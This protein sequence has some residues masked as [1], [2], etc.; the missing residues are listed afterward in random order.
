MDDLLQ[1]FLTEAAE[2]LAILDVELVKF[3]QDPN[4]TAI[5]QNIFRLVHTVKG[6]C[7]FLGLSRLEAV[8]HA[9]ENVLGKFRD[10][11]LTV[12]PLAV[13]LILRCL[14]GIRAILGVLEQTGQEPAG[15]DA[16]LI[17]ELNALASGEAPAA[18]ASAPAEV[19]HNDDSGP[20]LNEQ[21]FPV[22]AELLAEVAQALAAQGIPSSGLIDADA[23][24]QA[25]EARRAT[26]SAAEEAMLA[27]MSAEENRPQPAAPAPVAAAPVAAAPVAAAPAAGESKDSAVAGASIRV[28]VDILENLMTLVS[29][30]VLTRNQLLQMVRVREDSEFKTP[31][32]R[33]SHITTE[34]Q[35]GVMKSRMQPIGNAWSKLPRIVRDLSMELD[36][37]VELVMQGADT[38]LDR[39]LLELIKDPLTHMV[40]NSVDHGLEATNKDRIAAGK[41]EV[42]KITLKAY[43]EGGHIIISIADDGRGLNAEK[44]RAKALANGLVTEAELTS[45]SDHQLYQFIFRAGFSTAEKVTNVSGRGV[46]MDVV[47]SNIEKIGGTI[48][49]RSAPNKGTTFTIK[50]PLTLAIVSAL[51]VECAKQRFAIPQINVLELVRASRNSEARI[52]E[53]NH[54]PVLRLRDRLLPLVSLNRLLKIEDDAAAAEDS[55]SIVIAQVGNTKFGMIV[56]R[57]FDTEEIVVKPVSSLMRNMPVYSGNT[58]LGDGNVIMILDPHGIADSLGNAQLEETQTAE[59]SKLQQSDSTASFLL[60]RAVGQEVKAIPLGLVTRIERIPAANVEHTQGRYVVQYRDHLMPLV[61]FHETQEWQKGETYSVLVFTEKDRSV[62]LV[63]DAIVDIVED[64]MDIALTANQPGLLGSAVI[65]GSATD[66]IDAGHFLTLGFHDWF[67]GVGHADAAPSDRREVLLV[68][69]SLFFRNLMTPYLSAAG[70]KVT[71]CPSAEEALALRETGR[72][73]S[74]IVSDLE[75]P[76]LGGMGFARDVKADPRWRETPFVALSALATQGIVEKSYDA[77]CDHYVAKSNREELLR[78]MN[79]AVTNAAS[80]EVRNSPTPGPQAVALQPGAWRAA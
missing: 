1:E 50:I 64:R 20:V 66:V 46:G 62:G 25:D 22:A 75:M 35:E 49:L 74:V 29:E 16:V 77:G 32:Q 80:V 27:M 57:V 54:S 8:A 23:Q 12:T 14:D 15:D 10:G 2:N 61:P 65:A 71:T 47:R 76:G 28:S 48:E 53:I 41:S 34:L 24:A 21:G 37:K 40:R 17:A 63:V 4:D 7:G 3:E 33:L 58:I 38:E 9:G 26:E 79:Q 19:A 60:F 43:H 45:M 13:T 30:L 70:W 39:Q 78:T 68:D 56:D 5:L 73:F 31:L 51:V 18:A 69:D 11:E 36:K 44:I 52:E 72:R 6:T 55:R 59:A 42:G 67:G